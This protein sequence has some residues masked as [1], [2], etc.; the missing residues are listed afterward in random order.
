MSIETLLLVAVAAGIGLWPQIKAM[1]P[2]IGPLAKKIEQEIEQDVG[3][4]TQ[5]Q[6]RS[7][8]VVS[9][10]RLQAYCQK[11]QMTKAVGLCN[12]LC[13]ELISY[14][15]TKPSSSTGRK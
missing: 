10:M 11:S 1:F 4:A 7:D 5:E 9:M 3:Q 6:T 13:N 12:E 15:P 2:G 14:K 8:W